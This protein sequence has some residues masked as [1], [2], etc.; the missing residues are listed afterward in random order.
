LSG[1]QDLLTDGEPETQVLNGRPSWAGKPAHEFLSAAGFYLSC[2]S[3]VELD[4]RV[5][6]FPEPNLKYLSGLRACASP[7]TAI[8]CGHAALLMRCEPAAKIIGR[9]AGVAVPIPLKRLGG[10]ERFG[11][12]GDRPIVF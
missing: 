11:G 4:G 2:L 7:I 3:E 12:A 10:F 1:Q 8:R 6:A 9:T 5:N